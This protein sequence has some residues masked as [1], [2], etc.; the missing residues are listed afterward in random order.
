MSRF[1]YASRSGD[2]LI[3]DATH[4]EGGLGVLVLE[5]AN[6]SRHVLGGVALSVQATTPIWKSRPG[7]YWRDDAGQL[8][9]G[10][11]ESLGGIAWDD[12]GVVWLCVPRAHAF[13]AY[14]LLSA[15]AAAAEARDSF[16]EMANRAALLA[17]RAARLS[18]EPRAEQCGR[19]QYRV[20]A[21][22]SRQWQAGVTV[23]RLPDVHKDDGTRR[24]QYEVKETDYT[25]DG[26]VDRVF[27]DLAIT[28]W[29]PVEFFWKSEE[30]AAV[31]V[32]G[33]PSQPGWAFPFRLP[34]DDEEWRLTL[35]LTRD[36]VSVP[37]PHEEIASGGG[38]RAWIGAKLN[39]A[40]GADIV[41]AFGAGWC[42]FIDPETFRETPIHLTLRAGS[43]TDPQDW[44]RVSWHL[45][46]VTIEA[47]LP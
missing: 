35:R 30:G 41:E 45:P 39:A 23:S 22:R 7:R 31:T 37:T 29:E 20:T 19:G 12:C 15:A 25:W 42:S 40:A 33:P 44:K 10:I 38:I 6:Q 11:A 46:D 36:G 5:Y 21:P 34:L 16:S 28:P 26:D 43:S 17:A 27:S 4:P 9:G 24:Q 3:H 18:W 32:G 13:E 8:A 14:Q 47:S 1:I 2:R